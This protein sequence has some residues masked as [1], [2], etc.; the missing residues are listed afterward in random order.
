MGIVESN[1]KIKISSKNP[2]FLFFVNSFYDIKKYT[3]YIHF[4]KRSK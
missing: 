4:L 3:K 2:N 1:F